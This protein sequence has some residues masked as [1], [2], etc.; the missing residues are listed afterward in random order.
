MK[1]T[2]V[3]RLTSILIAVI[4]IT[5]A[6]SIAAEL[7]HGKQIVEEIIVTS[8]FH[9]SRADTA[10]S[11][12]VL[13]GE[14]L[15]EKAGATLG[16]TLQDQIG[17]NIA[18]FGPGVGAPVIRGHSANRVQI[19]QGG[20]GNIDASSISADHTSS[21]EPSLA[22]RIEV[23]RGPA[24]LLYGNGAIGGVVNIIDNRIPTSLPNSM[25][26]ML[27]TRN[28]SASDQQVSVVK[29]ESAIGQLAWHL[30]GI[31]RDSNDIEIKGFAINPTLVDLSKPQE[32]QALLNSK[33][34]LNNSNARAQVMTV[35]GSW[36]LNEGHIGFSTNHLENEYGIP[37]AFNGGDDEGDVRIVMEQDRVD[38]ELL[39]PLRGMF[40]EVHG[41][42]STVDYQHAEVEQSGEI[43]TLFQQDGTE[44]RFVFDLNTR[45][46]H[47]AVLGVQFSHRKFSAL[48]EEAF[49]PKTDISSFA[50][51]TVHS[52]SSQNT[53]YEFGLRG[54]QQRVKQ[55][56]GNCDESNTSWSGSAALIWRFSENT[57]LLYSIAHSQR[58]ATV[59]ELY[60]NIDTQCSALASNELIA[61]AATQRLEIGNPGADR[62]KS[63]NFEIGLR[64]HRGNVTGEVSIYRNDIADYI[65]LF[66][67]GLFIN[68]MEISR[69][70]QENVVFQGIEA[71]LSLPLLRSKNNL[72]DLVIFG[73][74]V[75]AKFNHI[76]NVPRIPA[77]RYGVELKHSQLDWQTKLRLTRVNDQSNTAI[78]E[79][80]TDGYI[81]LNLYMD[82][83][84]Q[85]CKNSCLLFVKGINLLDQEIRHHTSLL[86]DVAP[87]SGRGFEI[88]FRFEF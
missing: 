85:L 70:T 45:E 15:R 55:A 35:G 62:E 43:G 66:D 59:E 24:T 88:G 21:I 12:N 16:D 54:E 42:V 31:Y 49:I 14:E 2:F 83:H 36:I 41:R 32:Y 9:N 1:Q 23:L 78:N 52:L 56:D 60:S 87:A 27:E 18:S 58:S 8:S 39:L 48:G 34:T 72:V 57:N 73:D 81:L 51:F 28:N 74:H 68:D 19:L 67:T 20:V 80:P 25:S 17:V 76:G 63:T 22:E 30:D 46:N 26:G 11:V 75:A 86:K 40:E 79:S 6:L 38:F 3:F 71:E 65:Y 77:S 84:V 61:H 29:L 64:K 44:G 33:G 82:Y 37:N 5:P 10:L 53:I 4:P 7:A 69:Y 13:A 50:L 47:E